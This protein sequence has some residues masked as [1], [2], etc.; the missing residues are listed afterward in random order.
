MAT[1]RSG[2]RRKALGAAL[3]GV[4]VAPLLASCG[5][6]SSGGTPTLN[7]YIASTRHS[8]KSPTDAEL[9]T[10]SNWDKAVTS[11]KDTAGVVI[12]GTV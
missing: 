9:A 12:L 8:G 5:G 11:I 2:T 1:V 3:A 4:V 6:G 7:W 10:G